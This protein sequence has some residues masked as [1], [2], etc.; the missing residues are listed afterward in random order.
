M[1]EFKIFGLK[2]FCPEVLAFLALFIGL[3]LMM[4]FLARRAIEREK[5][6]FT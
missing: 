3:M 2:C 6:L 5:V 1:K 4:L